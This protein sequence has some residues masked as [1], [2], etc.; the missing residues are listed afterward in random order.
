[1]P[2]KG[3]LMSWRR[4]RPVLFLL[5]AL[6]FIGIVCFGSRSL[7]L[8]STNL[9]VQFVV[10][11]GK[12]GTPIEGA[13]IQVKSYGGFYATDDEIRD[14][15]GF[16]LTTNNDGLAS[17]EC[18]RTWVVSEELGIFTI[19]RHVRIPNWVYAVG[20][21]EYRDTEKYQLD[22]HENGRA[23]EHLGSKSDRLVIRIALIRSDQ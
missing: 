2:Y 14:A 12:T 16:S 5:I 9:E 7:S 6:L 8:G 21:K 22:T 3:Y 17:R 19:H 4:L 18:K 10:V 13:L 20:A 23:T 15:E 11:D 1:M